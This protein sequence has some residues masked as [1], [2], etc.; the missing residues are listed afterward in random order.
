MTLVFS[1]I[2][3]LTDIDRLGELKAQIA[4]IQS[5]ADGLT[6]TIKEMGA[7]K[8]D[9]EMFSAT[10]SVIDERWSADPKAIA[11]KLLEVMGREAFNRFT[12]CHQKKTVGYTTLK[13][14]A[15]D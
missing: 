1:R 9:G 10:V 2:S 15:R 13:L 4:D 8:H 3:N 6:A 12:A 7:G 14:T 11:T 5:V